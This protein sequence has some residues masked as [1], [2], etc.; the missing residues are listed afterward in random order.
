[1]K[2]KKFYII[3]FLCFCLI[4]SL[5]F[6]PYLFDKKQQSSYANTS[7]SIE[8]C[9]D[10]IDFFRGNI[11][12]D[13]NRYIVMLYDALYN[14]FDLMKNGS[15]EISLKNYANYNSFVSL[16]TE[17]KYRAWAGAINAIKY[18]VPEIFFVNFTEVNLERS[19]GVGYYVI[20][21]DNCYIEGISSTV[22][23]NS[24]LNELEQ[25]R[26][27]IYSQM[28]MSW[29]DYQKVLFVNNYLVENVEYDLSL[30]KNFVHTVYGSIVNNVAVCDGYSYGGQYLLDGLGI[31][32]LVCAGYAY[33]PSTGSSEGHMWSYVNLYDHWYGLDI[34]WNDPIIYGNYSESFLESL[35]TAYFLKGW[36][37]ETNRGF[38]LMD[39][40][41]DERVVQNYELYF[42][43]ND[44]SY[45]I[46]ELPYPEIEI[47]DYSE[48]FFDV[49][50]NNSFE[51]DSIVS[52]KITLSA[53]NILENM[54]FAYK[55]SSDGELSFG[56][57]ISCEDSVVFDL[58][59]QNG[60]YK[61]YI[62]TDEGKIVKEF[63]NSFTIEVGQK[64][65]LQ[66]NIPDGCEY[67]I[68]PQ[69]EDYIAGD[70]VS[71]S[72][73]NL[74]I[75]KEID[76]ISSEQVQIFSQ[77]GEY[78]FNFPENDVEIDVSLKDIVYEVS[79]VNFDSV[80]YEID[81]T[82][83]IYN[84]KVTIKISEVPIGKRIKAISFSGNEYTINLNE[85]FSFLMPAENVS[86]EL[87][88]EDIVYN[89]SINAQESLNINIPNNS[90]YNQKVYIE[91]IDL[92]ENEKII[93]SCSNFEIEF[94]I[95]SND[96]IYFIMPAQDITLDIITQRT[97]IHSIS[98]NNKEQV[99]CVLNKNEAYFGEEVVLQI[100]KIELG[101]IV[102]DV[103][104]NGVS[105]QKVNENEYNFIMPEEN[106]TI[107]V[108]LFEM[109]KITFANN[110]LQ[111]EYELKQNGTNFYYIITIKNLPSDKYV[112]SYSAVDTN[113][114][115]LSMTY[116]QD[117]KYQV[118]IA[119]DDFIVTF[120][121]DD[122]V[123][124]SQS[125][126]ENPDYSVIVLFFV[127]L[128]VVVGIV[129]FAVFK[130]RD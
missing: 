24:M 117:N 48:P 89:I 56:D 76:Q 13:I 3:N 7:V 97:D 35:K 71:L 45:I 57:F 129:S 84:E 60:I 102:S 43:L 62:I 106:V 123:L 29:T 126:E 79:F 90:T 58:P 80:N 103:K 38:Y 99:I 5:A 11:N 130:N 85:E 63:T 41:E 26:E 61:F 2:V 96:I 8:Q 81:K 30:S 128:V 116:L 127:G 21:S 105:A 122:K 119:S 87:L 47:E 91:A 93:A 18:D 72:F 27:K 98:I 9:D 20:T 86:I 120:S 69:K 16:S 92:P 124:P 121:L 28:D 22:Q 78:C 1:M 23:L 12:D 73:T 107:E 66:I 31:N 42:Q 108:E 39:E 113:G 59:S 52:S 49:S 46:Y 100:L 104:V 15:F 77:E 25:T 68:S 19:Y 33:N 36:N 101:F 114:K 40:D 51:G 95:V 112:K 44:G 111:Y 75:G 64:Y 54:H 10:Y 6:L 109:P 65:K 88:L 17:E 32:N 53:T 94:E 55:Y 74:P 4:L 118:N 82:Q 50:L 67:Q 14:N 115:K 70:Y 34:T 125:G 83:A 37:K 110:E